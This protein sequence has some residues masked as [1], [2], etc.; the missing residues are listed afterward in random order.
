MGNFDPYHVWLQI[1]PREQPPTYYR[2]LGLANF[3][4]DPEVIDNAAEQRLLHLRNA[5]N[6]AKGK[7]AQQLM[8]E[9]AQARVTLLQ[10]EKRAE[11]DAHLHKTL[12]SAAPTKPKVVDSNQLENN[13]GPALVVE[14]SSSAKSLSA[15]YS[16]KK[17]NSSLV[18]G[19]V[20]LTAIVVLAGLVFVIKGMGGGDAK[21]KKEKV[22]DNKQ[23]NLVKEK[24]D[25]PNTDLGKKKIGPRVGEKQ[26]VKGHPVVGQKTHD[27]EKKT[28]TPTPK[29]GV[30]NGGSKSKGKSKKTLVDRNPTKNRQSDVTPKRTLG[31]NVFG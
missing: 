13:K 10:A 28:G 4:S 7:I 3:E 11:Y 20:I 21:T 31:V 16:R 12:S 29:S 9:V 23:N 18:M 24:T 25:Q 8:N 2:L 1:P 30:G 15:A 17:K 5:Q 19:G 6:G 27:P 26:K 22:A 14:K